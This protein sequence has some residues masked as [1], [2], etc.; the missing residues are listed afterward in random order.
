MAGADAVLD[1]VVIMV[2]VV[3]VML[4][5]I[6]VAVRDILIMVVRVWAY[7]LMPNLWYDILWHQ[8]RLN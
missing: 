7:G 3:V 1:S 4:G 2:V 8:V 6:G 5:V